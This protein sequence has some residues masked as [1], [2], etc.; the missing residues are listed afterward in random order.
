MGV[1]EGKLL[2]SF[3]TNLVKLPG[4]KGGR[5]RDLSEYLPRRKELGRENNKTRKNI[6]PTQF[7]PLST[8]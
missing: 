1:E 3:H 5:K 8:E 7:L 2:P 6:F 4:K